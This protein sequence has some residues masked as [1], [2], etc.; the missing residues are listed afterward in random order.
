MR[1]T[2]CKFVDRMPPKATL[3]SGLLQVAQELRRLGFAGASELA[4]KIRVRFVE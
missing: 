1:D 3:Q 2:I 4:E